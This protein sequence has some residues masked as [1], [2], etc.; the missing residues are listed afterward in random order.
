MSWPP[1]RKFKTDAFAAIHSSASALHNVGAMSK[2]TMRDFD[3]ECL[4]TLAE[5]KPKQI[6]KIS[7]T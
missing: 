1:K 5:I 3:A 2:A 4:T 6:K 7:R